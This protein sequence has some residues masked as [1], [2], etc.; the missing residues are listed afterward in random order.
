MDS[1]AEVVN[2]SLS[3]SRIVV[4]NDATVPS[5]S[6]FESTMNDTTTSSCSFVATSSNLSHNDESNDDAVSVLHSSSFL[7]SILNKR[8]KHV[9]FSLI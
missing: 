1:E 6:L 4:Y 5:T 9:H 7:M 2:R 3:D 8:K